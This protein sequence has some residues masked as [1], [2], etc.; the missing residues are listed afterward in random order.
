VTD[1][2][3]PY[4]GRWVALVQGHIAGMGRTAEEAR[5]AAQLARPKEKPQVIFVPEH[6]D[7]NFPSLVAELRNL[8]PAPEKTWLVGGAVR[9]ALLNR[10]LR[11][12]DFAV[13]GDALALARAAANALSAPFYPLDA[14]RD[15]GRVIVARDDE[16]FT[17]D[18]AR[19]RAPDLLADLAARDF[20][21]NAMAVSMAEPENLIDPLNGEADLRAKIIRACASHAIADDPIRGIRA[22]RLAAQ[23]DFRLDPQTRADVRAQ[24]S[25]LAQTTPER[26]RDEFIR[27]LGG[28]RPAAAL[29]ALELLGLLEHLAPEVLPLK[30]L[31]Q[32]PPHEL[33]AWEHTLITVARLDEVLN[34]L[35]PVHDVDAASDLTHG[36]ISLRLGRFRRPLAEHLS[37]ALSGD[38][39]ARWLLMLAALLH[40]AGKAQTRTVEPDGRIRFLNHE[41]VGAEL[42]GGRLTR[43]R[44]S[45]DEVRRVSAVIAHHMRARHLSKAQASPSRRAVYRFFRDAGEAGVDIVLLSLADFLAKSS[46]GPPPQEEWAKHVGVCAELL[47]AYFER[48][49]ESVSPPSLITGHDLIAEF[50]L[51]AGPQIGELLETVREAQAA[52]E[53]ADRAGALEFVRQRLAGK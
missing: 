41:A 26:R 53:I 19:L 31:A 34:V 50:N 35:G 28:P 8:L 21:I 6:R 45:A 51:E 29:R 46:S 13:D 3:R 9:D 4:A 49:H 40:D 25:A 18:F 32:S 10:R 38:R 16:R 17:L 39:P 23:L 44:F 52:G 5:L 42:A 12:L 1:N 22:I 33:E 2:L 11:D 7:L 20:T 37:Q 48:P 30:G 36:L 47:G 24:A 43:L 15:V 14:E 27:C